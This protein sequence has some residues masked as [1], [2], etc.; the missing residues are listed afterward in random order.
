MATITET[1]VGQIA[2]AEAG[3]IEAGAITVKVV[4]DR[5]G[6]EALAP[7]WD[8]TLQRSTADT[9]FLTHE[10]LS[11]WVRHFA[12]RRP[13]A[14]LVATCGDKAVG[15]APLMIRRRDRFNRL[16]TLGVETLDYED[17]ILSGNAEPDRAGIL[18][19]LVD[20][21]MA[22]PC[23]DY[24]QFNRIPGDSDTVELLQKEWERRGLRWS[25]APSE[26][27]PYVPISGSWDQYY[28][29]LSSRLRKNIRR[30]GRQLAQAVGDVVIEGARDRVNAPAALESL[31]DLHA[32]RRKRLDRAP[33]LFDSDAVRRFYIDLCGALAARG[34]VDVP[35]LHAGGE[36]AAVQLNFR[37]GGLY[38]KALPAFD[39]SFA[40]Y[41][42]GRMLNIHVMRQAFETGF[43]RVDFLRGVERYKFDFKPEVRQLYSLAVYAPTLRG[44]LAR[45]WFE[46]VRPVVKSS[47]LAHALMGRARS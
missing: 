43:S 7:V 15:L 1:S 47:R 18:S 40:E 22:L 12:A 20:A 45:Q 23:W 8:A 14:V 44:A 41:A 6:F 24:W 11:T 37:Y 9:V 30:C 17:I 32:T 16:G 25:L 36:L 33:G 42:V 21:A 27:S 28:E 38:M 2:A 26:Q 46:R 13:L 19:A 10:W 3:A 39:E 34:W 5:A 29:S 4:R 35:T 31:F